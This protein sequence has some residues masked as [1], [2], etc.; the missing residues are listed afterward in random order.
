MFSIKEKQY[1]AYGIE[2]LLLELKHPEMPD[3]EPIFTLSVKGKESCSWAE[4]KP[5]WEFGI[6][7]PPKVNPFNEVARDILKEPN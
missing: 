5:N 6:D 1:L 7:N 4:I 2:K 3:K